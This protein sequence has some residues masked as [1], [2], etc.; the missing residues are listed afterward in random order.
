MTTVD[1]FLLNLGCVYCLTCRSENKSYVGQAALYK[2]KDG[3]PYSYGLKG[4]W[5]DHVADA[6][7]KTKPIARAITTY[8]AADF[9]LRILEVA[10]LVELSDLEATYIR[11]LETWYP[12]GYNVQ[13]GGLCGHRTEPRTADRVLFAVPRTAE[14]VRF[15]E[16]MRDYLQYELLNKYAERLRSLE[17]LTLTKV[18]IA[19]ARNVSAR[20]QDGQS[21][22]YTTVTVYLHTTETKMA[23]DALKYRFGG[24]HVSLSEAYREAR[25]FVSYLPI[26][27][28]IPIVDQVNVAVENR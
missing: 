23:K 2:F 9:E 25:E 18:R 24:V 5:S 8:G 11:T 13:I 7:T 26:T 4:R 27:K 17:G 28:E 19:T 21:K 20:R 3:K 14:V 1:P 6:P 16:Q 22:A 15:Y 10:P 12:T